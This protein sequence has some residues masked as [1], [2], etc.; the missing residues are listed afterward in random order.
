MIMPDDF[1]KK[2]LR[3]ENSGGIPQKPRLGWIDQEIDF[4]GMKTKAGKKKMGQGEASAKNPL[5]VEISFFVVGGADIGPH[6]F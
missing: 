3:N 2:E 4:V 6:N 5:G 1:A